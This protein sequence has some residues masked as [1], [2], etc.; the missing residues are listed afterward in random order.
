MDAVL[1]SRAPKVANGPLVLDLRD[2]TIGVGRLGTRGIR[3]TDEYCPAISTASNE[4]TLLSMLPSR[5]LVCPQ[6]R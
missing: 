1:I 3:G 5:F 4:M 6:L 2:G